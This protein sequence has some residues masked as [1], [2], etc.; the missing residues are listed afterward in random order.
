MPILGS[1][2]RLSRQVMNVLRHRTTIGAALL[3]AACAIALTLPATALAERQQPLPDYQYWYAMP[4]TKILPTTQP[5][6]L[7]PRSTDREVRGL[8]LSAAQ[9]EFEGRQI[10]IRPFGADLVDLSIEASDL[11]CDASGGVIPAS[12]VEAFK[13][14]YVNVQYPS[15]PY[16][17]KGLEPDPLLPMTL[18]NGQPL[19]WKASGS[20]DLTR[21]GAKAWKTQ[22]FYVLFHVPKG[23]PAGTYTGVLRVSAAASTG[24]RTRALRIPVRLVVHAFSIDRRTLKTSFGLNLRWA[25]YTSSAAH[26]WL[27]PNASPPLSASRIPERTTYKGDQ[28][29]GWLRYM[30]DHRISPQTM[31]PAWE[32]G[33]DWAPPLDNGDMRVRDAYLA[34]CLGTGTATSF[35]GN[36][37]AFDSVCMPEYGEPAYVKDP[38]ASSTNRS[39]AAQYYRTMKSEL[40]TNISRAYAYPVDEPRAS[41]RTLVEK[42]AQLVHQ[43]APGVK[44]MVTTDPVTMN[45]KPLAGVDIYTH[46]LQ[47]FYRDQP[48]WI[49]PLRNLKKEIWI[50]SHSTTWQGKVPMYLVDKPLAESRVQ[51][52]FVYHSRATGLLHFDIAA[53][54]PKTGSADYRD[55]Y[56]DPLSYRS[57]VDGKP[58]YGNGDGSLVY[59]G[60]YPSLGLV[61]EGSPPVGSLRMEALR[62][63]LEDYEYLK[64][65]ESKRGR[66]KADAYV[67]RII[68]SV[69]AQKPGVLRFPTYEKN[70]L[71]YERVRRDMAAEI[72]R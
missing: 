25:A 30:S 28:V 31:L 5:S 43:E 38:F 35:P 55:P 48:T 69:P 62:D 33:S 45:Y 53:W 14:H 6:V 49:T 8:S 46:K 18:V 64:I 39:K 3:G 61:V 68:G 54:R 2:A 65:I 21:R 58:I 72:T 52:W 19:G 47:F 24:Q 9:A 41:E 1:D 57:S 56:A 20:P 66:A 42:Y 27:A 23:T 59:P 15:Y 10:A 44:Y 71:P 13:V 16:T 12:E 7:A 26:G 17:R 67:A 63:G 60:Y 36:Q 11:V 37:L 29:G 22:P 34:D 40:G 4:Q 50:Y 70:A 32:S 51:G